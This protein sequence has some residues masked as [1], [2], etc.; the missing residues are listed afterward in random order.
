MN[1]GNSWAYCDRLPFVLLDLSGC[2]D[3]VQ[4]ALFQGEDFGFCERLAHKYTYPQSICL[5]YLFAGP[6]YGSTPSAAGTC[7]TR[8]VPA[9]KVDQLGTFVELGCI[10]SFRHPDSDT[11]DG[12]QPKVEG[13]E[14]AT[15]K[16]G[17]LHAP[18]CNGACGSAK[19]LIP[20]FS[21][22]VARFSH[23]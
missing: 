20:V 3:E 4:I 22:D 8:F 6:G 1:A 14:C 12:P 21:N 19:K 9:H 10:E 16:S 2:N 7:D 11:P 13:Y 5:N 17:I 18:A 15:A 23:K